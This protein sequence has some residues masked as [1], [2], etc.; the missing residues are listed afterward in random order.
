MTIDNMRAAVAAIYP[1]WK[2]VKTMTDDQVL[3]IFRSLQKRGR[4]K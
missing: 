4:V 2:A 3:A 1:G